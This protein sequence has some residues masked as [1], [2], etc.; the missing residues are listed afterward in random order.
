[1]IFGLSGTFRLLSTLLFI[2]LVQ[3]TKPAPSLRPATAE[4]G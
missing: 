4:Q 3:E 1:L 2:R